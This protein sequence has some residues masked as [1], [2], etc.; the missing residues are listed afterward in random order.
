MKN[1]VLTLLVLVPFLAFSQV[2]LNSNITVNRFPNAISNYTVAQGCEKNIVFSLINTSNLQQ[3]RAVKMF[4]TDVNGNVLN[5]VFEDVLTFAPNETKTF[6]RD[7]HNS[8]GLTVGSTPD[9]YKLDLRA[10]NTSDLNA[11][12][13][14]SPQISC[15]TG[16]TNC[17][18]QQFAIIANT[19]NCG[20]TSILETLNSEINIFPNPASENLNIVSNNIINNIEIVDVTGKIQYSQPKIDSKYFNIN[21]SNLESGIYFL[22]INSKNQIII[23]N[24][25]IY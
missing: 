11:I 15:N 22:K 18:P 24:I 20:T 3:V 4:L 21:V 5:V 13:I 7:T 10:D 9:N 8:L 1:L 12:S 23:K 14:T 16:V 6:S 17:N 19:D 25:I 2:K